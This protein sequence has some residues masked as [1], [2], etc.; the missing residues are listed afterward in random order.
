MLVFTRKS[1]ESLMIGDQIKI[2]ILSS[3]SDSVRI[4]ISA[5]RQ[6]PV[7]RMEVYE[8]IKKQNEK[9]VQSALPDGRILARLKKI[10]S[11]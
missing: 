9:A 4:G 3:G 6:I 5:P 8:A 2:K 10:S 7:H 1:G 11:Q